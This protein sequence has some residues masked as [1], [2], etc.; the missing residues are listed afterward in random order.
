MKTVVFGGGYFGRNYIR[1]LGHNLV[2]VIEPD[3]ANAEYVHKTYNVPVYAE[4]PQDIQFDGAVIVTPPTSHVELAKGLLAQ[5]YYVLIEKPFAISVEEAYQL[6]RWRDKCMAAMIYLYHPSVAWLKE[7]VKFT[8]LN[9]IYTRRTNDGPIRPWQNALWD[10]AAHDVSIC[11]YILGQTPHALEAMGSR[12]RDW[13]MLR[14]IYVAAEAITYVSW[15]GGP[16]VR[17]VEL[18]PQDGHDRIIFDDMQ[19]ALEIS[20][21]RLM[22]N[23]FLS[24]KWDERGAFETGIEVTNV[25]EKAAHM[26]P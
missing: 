24:G 15:R 22:L 13:A 18:V 25:L 21:M 11:N 7:V 2:A 4:L 5:G 9:H 17:T 26:I 14:S 20:P 12:S 1:E 6:H 10:L 19:T 16:K 23:A 3:P 8:P